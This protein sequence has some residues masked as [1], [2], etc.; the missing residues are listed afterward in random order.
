MKGKQVLGLKQHKKASGFIINIIS[1]Y[2]PKHFG[3]DPEHGQDPNSY[4][5]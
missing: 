3:M 4:L 1:A 2:N 5:I